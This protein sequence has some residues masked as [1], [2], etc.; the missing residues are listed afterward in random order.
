M[1][2]P[3]SDSESESNPNYHPVTHEVVI[4]AY[5]KTVTAMAIDKHGANMVTGNIE[6]LLKYW[7]FNGMNRGLKHYREITPNESHAII[8]LDFNCKGSLLLCV[9]SDAQCRI[10]DREG[11]NKAI[12]ITALGDMYVRDMAVTK[13]HTKM[14]TDG[15]WHP[16]R[17]EEW[18]T[19]SMDG[20]LRIWNLQNAH[21]GMD[22]HLTQSHVLKTV[23]KRGVPM[24]ATGR[25]TTGLEGV[26]PTCCRYTPD[27]KK[28]I[29][30]CSDGSIQIFH[31]KARYVK[32]DRIIREHG[33]GADLTGI[34]LFGEKMLSRSLD[35]TMK[36][37]NF[38]DFNAKAPPEREWKDLPTESP[39]TQCGVCPD[40][41]YAVTATCDK[42]GQNEVKLF[43]MSTGEEIIASPMVAG[44]TRLHW[45]AQIN[46]IIIGDV[47]GGVTVKYNTKSSRD[48]ALKFANKA[49]V[50]NIKTLIDEELTF[51][52]IV[53]P[54]DDKSALR[55][56]G[57]LLKRDGKLKEMSKTQRKR[58]EKAA[59]QKT[60]TPNFPGT[61]NPDEH[62]EEKKE[63]H[64]SISTKAYLEKFG[65]NI[66]ST[67]DSQQ[68]LLSYE[69]DGK[70]EVDYLMKAYKETQPEKILDW[71][72]RDHGLTEG[73]KL[74]RGRHCPK[75]GKKL[76]SCGYMAKE[77][78]RRLVKEEKE[79]KLKETL[80]RREAM[81]E[82]AKRKK[83]EEKN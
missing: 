27:A 81:D 51:N 17:P 59:R 12:E 56:H 9:T 5:E 57:I 49:D 41:E 24:G 2:E 44:A 1:P 32:P 74:L 63:V 54:H 53:V 30:G 77:E 38:Q 6:G 3:E 55:Q 70:I 21:V 75:C 72:D 40:Q 7:D 20:S 60:R 42:K 25:T 33:H 76:C 34:H 80:A 83:M 62:V 64:M 35:G 45:S 69:D 15:Q 48:G 47:K 66:A 26:Y 22:R 73:E 37:W 28:M 16:D 14:L 8:A 78:E 10:F 36:L 65:K 4:P 29:A 23:D 61:F 82:M 31:E 11:S 19:S 46:Q 50:R 13:G 58:E 79:K 67:V 39:Y 68:H 52:Q 71:S 43:S 18:L